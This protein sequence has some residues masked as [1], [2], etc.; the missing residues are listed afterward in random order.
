MPP[1]ELHFTRDELHALAATEPQSK[2]FFLEHAER[3]A[4]SAAY[5]NAR[6]LRSATLYCSLY[7]CADC[8]R[9]IVSAGITRLVVPERA[10]DPVRDV[11][12]AQHYRYAGEIFERARVT[13]ETVPILDQLA[14]PANIISA[15]R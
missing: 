4:I 5:K 9:A 6:E 10:L 11:K 13:I 7:P 3:N 12:W 8:A 14:S 2:Y 15:S 1:E